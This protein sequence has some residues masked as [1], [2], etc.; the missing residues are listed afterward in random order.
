[1]RVRYG[2]EALELEIADDGPG[3][4]PSQAKLPPSGHSVVGMR[5][6]VALFGGTLRT[7]P[8]N[9]R[10]YRVEALLPYGERR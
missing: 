6:R 10:G 3:P 2:D 5:E 1:V 9:G 4:D 7:G 8:V